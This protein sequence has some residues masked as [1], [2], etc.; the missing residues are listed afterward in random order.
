MKPA[1]TTSINHGVVT[2]LSCRPDA[3]RVPEK[4]RQVRIL[5]GL[6]AGT[7]YGVHANNATNLARGITER[8]LYVVRDG[9]LDKPPQPKDGVFKRLHALRARLVRCMPPTPIVDVQDYPDLYRGRKRA[10]YQ[11]AVDSLAQRGVSTVDAFV[12]TFLKAEK[13]NFSAKADPAP[14]VIQPRSPRYNVMVGRYLKLFE[15]RVFAGFARAFRYPVVLKGLNAHQ[16]GE[17]LHEHWTQFERPVA[18]GLDAS[19]FD[20]HVSRA[21]L[22]FE[23]GFYNAAFRSA[24]LRSLLRWQLRNRGI[25]RVPGWRF[26][27][28]TDGCRMS[29]DINT[30]LGN[31]ILM[32]CMVI[33]YCEHVGIKYRLAN[34]GDDCVVFLD[35]RDLSRLDGIGAWMLDFGFTLTREDPV[36]DLEKVVFCQAQPVLTST[37]WRMVRDPFTAMSKD[38]VSLVGWDSESAFKC[39]A[40]AIS[41][42]GLALT[43]G[44]PVWEAWYEQLRALGD[45]AESVGVAERVQECGMYHMSK[46]VVGGHVSDEARVSFWR[47]FGIM[48]DLQVSLEQW[49]RVPTH[50][51]PVTPMMFTDIISLDRSNNPLSTCAVTA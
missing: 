1:V 15:K 23:H 37:G 19:R 51:A 17:Q 42:C 4:E 2:G 31:C 8:V 25:A 5:A 10:V 22:E 21:A 28:T 41:T 50:V 39:W 45:G 48:P 49:Y 14:R 3:V 27:Y 9:R 47:A 44:V 26:D 38:C 18:V 16:V 7:N 46:G 12:S 29:G 32:S 43:R 40:S 24:E 36:Y 6:G 30:G 35:Q 34:N 20:Q 13:I 11:R 33:G